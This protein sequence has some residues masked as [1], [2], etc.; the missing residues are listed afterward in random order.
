MP[1]RFV[2]R[3]NNRRKYKPRKKKTMPSMS[4]T[5]ASATYSAITKLNSGSRTAM[6]FP[7]RKVIT[8]S[9][10]HIT[11]LSTNALGVTGAIVYRL[12]APYDP[13]QAA[14]GG[15]PV[16]W[17]Q[18]VAVYSH[19]KVLRANVTIRASNPSAKDYYI[20]Y[21]IRRSTDL[22]SLSLTYSQF[23]VLPYTH[24]E[25]LTLNGN[26]VKSLTVSVIPSIIW[27][28]TPKAMR[29]D[30]EYGAAVNAVPTKEVY[31]DVVAY[32]PNGVAVSTNVEIMIDYT[33]EFTGLYRTL[34][35]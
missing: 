29:I 22:S 10:A 4:R 23:K 9:W 28:E 3:T 18:M 35:A 7:N 16:Y 27:G 1:K 14:G 32:N 24:L 25:P 21:R 8:M 12:N 26:G 15:Q 5:P 20:G 6:P 31:I 19:Y 30:E 2:R 34:D 11:G 17:D 33:F 13:D